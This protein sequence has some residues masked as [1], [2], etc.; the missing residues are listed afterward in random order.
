M[1][2]TRVE[3]Q[4]IELVERTIAAIRQARE[5]GRIT[6]TEY[7]SQLMTLRDIRDTTQRLTEERARLAEIEGRNADVVSVVSQHYERNAVVVRELTET[8]QVLAAETLE[9]LEKSRERQT[10]INNLI[11]DRAE[12]QT[13][14]REALTEGD[15]ERYSVLSRTLRSVNERLAQLGVQTDTVRGQLLALRA[16]AEQAIE[17]LSHASFDEGSRGARGSRGIAAAS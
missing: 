2:R 10:E 5:E 8:Q 3:E 14:A 4:G 9:L 13:Q 15:L 12:L 6:G 11:R 1:P 17:A 16:Q 7:D